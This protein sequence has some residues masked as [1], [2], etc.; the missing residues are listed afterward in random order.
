[1]S[2]SL[3]L[4]ELSRRNVLLSVDGDTLRYKA[5]VGSLTPKLME[6]LRLFKPEVIQALHADVIAHQRWGLAP[7]EDIPLAL[8]PPRL[9]KEQRALLVATIQRQDS[10][11]VL[12]WILSDGG[13]ADKYETAR[14]WPSGVCDMA[15]VADLMLWQQERNLTSETRAERVQ[16]LVD[17]FLHP[18]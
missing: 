13:Q 1:M 8:Y 10:Q 15:A 6:E 14:K 9:D 11:E 2:A 3:L 7:P 16:E 12:A 17:S 5:P 4:Q 18:I